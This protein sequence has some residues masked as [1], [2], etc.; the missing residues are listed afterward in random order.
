MAKPQ[1]GEKKMKRVSERCES[2]RSPVDDG[3]WGLADSGSTNQA[4]DPLLFIFDSML[5]EIVP[6][7]EER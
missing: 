5:H 4:R 7:I 1:I 6:S 3:C 2:K